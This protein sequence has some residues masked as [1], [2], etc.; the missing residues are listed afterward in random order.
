MQQC[1]DDFHMQKRA[2]WLF[3][4]LLAI[5]RLAAAHVCEP[6]FA[7]HPQTSAPYVSPFT[8]VLSM[9]LPK[10]V[11]SA[12]F[13]WVEMSTDFSKLALLS[14]HGVFV[15]GAEPSGS[16]ASEGDETARRPLL[17]WWP[18][19][20]L[21]TD[22]ARSRCFLTFSPDSELLG[23]SAGLLSLRV[24]RQILV[25]N[26]SSNTP[27]ENSTAWSASDAPT[28]PRCA[29]RWQ[30]SLNE[31]TPAYRGFTLDSNTVFVASDG[32]LSA[33][34]ISNAED[35]HGNRGII[36][37]YGMLY[38]VRIGCDQHPHLHLVPGNLFFCQL[39]L[40]TSFLI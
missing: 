24:R 34:S 31:S 27:T 4:A 6:E 20:G 5:A 11:D 8:T 2:F 12:V 38:R 23:V 40:I 10:A 29:V 33:Y 3:F 22:C 26:V 30:L 19:D 7:G 32:N 13:D 9:Q 39:L 36:D 35:G 14:V 1:V 18:A 21:A 28:A 25:L 37:A 17:C 15:F 16:L